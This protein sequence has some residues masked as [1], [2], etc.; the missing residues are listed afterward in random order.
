MEKKDAL[1]LKDKP[2]IELFL[3]CLNESN[4]KSLITFWF[5]YPDSG[6]QPQIHFCPH[7]RP[8][9]LKAGH[10]YSKS[11]SWNSFAL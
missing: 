7:W 1:L 11:I 2:A 3:F 10:T 4:G 9:S 6:A 8:K 5:P